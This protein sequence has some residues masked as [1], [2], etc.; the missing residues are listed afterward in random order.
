[1]ERGNGGRRLL[2]WD[3]PNM[4]MCLSEA[5]G[6][7][8][9]AATR[10]N[11]AS[12]LA[13]LRDRAEP[14]DSVEACVFC[15][16]PA[17]VEVGMSAW[18]AGL[19]HAGL[20]VFV[21]PKRDRRDDVDADMLA[22]IDR[23]FTHGVLRQLIVASHDA[24]AFAA[25]L[26]RLAGEGVLVEVL[27]YREKDTFASNRPDLTFVDIEDVPGA[28][29]RPLPRTNLFDLPPSGRWFLPFPSASE[30]GA[31]RRA[32]PADPVPGAEAAGGSPPPVSAAAADEV[33]REGVLAEVEQEVRRAS[34]DGRE[35]LGL[36]EAGD[37]LR[38]RHP[39][40][41]LLDLGFASVV[42][43]VDALV[44]PGRLAL[45]RR[46]ADGHL[47]VAVGS[48]K[49]VLVQAPEESRPPAPLHPIY[50]AFGSAP[51]RPQT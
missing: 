1:M 20:A 29:E 24:K 26:R 39:D 4:D 45:V 14:G 13:W 19:R 5:I 34:A 42:E 17:G 10:P 18:I 44:A 35:G 6:E 49:P 51:D 41:D 12:V 47:L 30:S 7:R 28:F 15:N 43:L 37:L 23:R 36:R 27:G 21:K 2:V 11:L 9:S 33:T 32:A 46:P 38:R 22:H 31:D 25:P 8:A 3:A 16:V 48:T 50:R 40:H